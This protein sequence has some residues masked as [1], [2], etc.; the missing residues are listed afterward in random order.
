M[1]VAQRWVQETAHTL[2]VRPK[3][4]SGLAAS[5]AIG[6]SALRFVMSSALLTS[7][8]EA[9][10]G[11]LTPRVA[12]TFTY[13]TRRDTCTC[14]DF[15]ALYTSKQRTHACLI[16]ACLGALR[17]QSSHQRSCPVALQSNLAVG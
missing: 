6:S 17:K 4:L 12:V 1:R 13:S 8:G 7:S 5:M 2:V 10:G 3:N 15:Q 16:R 14:L 11:T 9:L